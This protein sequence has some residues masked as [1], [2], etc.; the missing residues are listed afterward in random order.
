MLDKIL[1]QEMQDIYKRVENNILKDRTYV[2]KVQLKE[3]VFEYIRN[4]LTEM[5]NDDIIIYGLSKEYEKV[6]SDYEKL[7]K[8]N[9][10]E[11]IQS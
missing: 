2:N 9:N 8:E 3:I 4:I 10:N 5:S 1:K 6:N 11:K 7:R